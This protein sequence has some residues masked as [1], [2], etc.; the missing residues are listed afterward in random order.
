VITPEQAIEGVYERFGRHLGFRALHAKGTLVRG[1]FTAA[2]EAAALTRAAHMQGTPVEVTARV[3]NAGGDPGVAD[4]ES[5]LR[6]LAVI[7]HLPD[8]SRTDIV[9]QTAPRFPVRTPDAF[10][11]L[12]RAQKLPAAI[13]RLPLFLVLHPGVLLTLP[14]NL[15]ALRP[16]ES[17]AT[18]RYYAIHAFR[19]LDGEGGARYVRY[20]WIP[21]LGDVRISGGDAKKR[22]AHYLQEDIAERLARE[23]VRFTLELQ[24]AADGDAVDDPTSVWPDERERVV[25]GTLELTSLDDGSTGGDSLVFDPV[26]MTDG[27]ELSADP[28]L[29]FR[30]RAY[31]VSAERRLSAS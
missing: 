10:I 21:E 23:P 29:S 11:E 14:A 17:Y 26:N 12:L 25:A 18:C 15:P 2:P 7:F 30:P 31:S 13:L 22:G 4:Y 6:G 8:G 27:I 24:V 9:S 16:P 28:V 19:W 1:S 5:D 20:T 3:S